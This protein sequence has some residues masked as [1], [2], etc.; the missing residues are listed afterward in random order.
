M[1][2][3][4]RSCRWSS[5]TGRSARSWSARRRP[6]VF[7]F[8]DLEL[9]Q[10]MSSESALAIERLRSSEALAAALWREQ[11]L[12][13]VSLDVRSELELEAGLAV[14]VTEMGEALGL[15]RCFVRLGDDVVAEWTRGRTAVDRRRA[16]GAPDLRRAADLGHDRVCPNVVEAE[17]IDARGAE[18]LVELG[19]RAGL[20]APIVVDGTTVGVLALHRG[21]PGPWSPELSRS[22]RP[23]PARRVSRSRRRFCSRRTAGGSRADRPLRRARRWRASSL[24]RGDPADRRGA[25]RGCWA[26]TPPIAGSGGG[27]PPR[28]L[29]GRQRPARDRG[30]PHDPDRGHT[31]AGDPGQR[32][33]AEAPVRRD[34]AA[35]R[36]LR[37]TSPR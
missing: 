33:G 13:R 26:P 37:G 34:D 29:P 21:E 28:A 11:L 12:G 1:C 9:L 10:A 23:S 15:S 17:E 30:R 31:G 24:R 19:T 25:L 2:A 16:R 7:T 14:G 20:P 5:T 27:R 22:P 32:A 3:A 8:E 6:R 18:L 4:S 35:E 36:E